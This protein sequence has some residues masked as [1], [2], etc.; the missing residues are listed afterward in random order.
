MKGDGAGMKSALKSRDPVLDTGK[1]PGCLTSCN[2][3]ITF[4]W[5]VYFKF[6]CV[7]VMHVYECGKIA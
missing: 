2:P 7:P 5:V 4:Y 1:T 6:F 3:N